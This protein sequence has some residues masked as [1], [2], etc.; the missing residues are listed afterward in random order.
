MVLAFVSLQKP[1]V[2]IL[3]VS[4]LYHFSSD[5]RCPSEVINTTSRE[6]TGDLIDMREE[7]LRRVGVVTCES[8]Y[9]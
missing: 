5:C 8:C 9:L 6:S 3:V 7:E 4:A 2:I 1:L